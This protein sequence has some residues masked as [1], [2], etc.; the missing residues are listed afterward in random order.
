M[1]K[2][3]N[4]NIKIIDVINDDNNELPFVISI[5]HSGLYLTKNMNDNMNDDVILA[6]SDWYLSELYSFLKE[7]GFTVV[8]NNINRY[9]IDPNR[10][11]SF[12][13]KD[14][15]S[16]SLIY[17]KTT[18]LKD[19]YKNSPTEE[20]IYYR[21]DNFYQKYHNELQKQINKKLKYFDKVFLIDLHS[22]G[23]NIEADIVLGNDNN[24]TMS[25]ELF[26]KFKECFTNNGFIVSDNIPYKGGYIV[27]KYGAYENC[28]SIQI[29]LSYKSYIE[30]REFIEEELPKINQHLMSDCQKKLKKT[31]NSVKNN[32]QQ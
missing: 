24:K 25:K 4:N 31:F 1:R 28:E 6:N 9:V 20:E 11:L 26:N 21:I 7:L 8:I 3:L 30:N 14:N 19:I 10:E 29:E 23:K 18:F 15:Y 32:I 16:K 13:N 22:F 2:V 17:M 12:E 27:R 5:P